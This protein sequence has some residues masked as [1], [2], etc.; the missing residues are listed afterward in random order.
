M[1]VWNLN[2]DKK[3]DDI[4]DPTYEG[5]FCYRNSSS[6]TGISCSLSKSKQRRKKSKK[7]KVATPKRPKT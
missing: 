4:D 1:G 7:T 3:E 2:R 6:W 5:E